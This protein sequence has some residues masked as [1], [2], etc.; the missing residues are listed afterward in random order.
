MVR[1]LSGASRHGACGIWH[2]EEKLAGRRREA[3]AE[4]DEPF[5]SMYNGKENKNSARFNQ[6]GG[7]EGIHAANDG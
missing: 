3:A 4:C 5:A 2:T 6:S 1:V 7:K